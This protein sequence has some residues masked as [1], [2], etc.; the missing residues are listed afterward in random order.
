MPNKGPYQMYPGENSKPSQYES[1]NFRD[2]DI[3]KAAMFPN[4]YPQNFAHAAREASKAGDKSFQY[5]GETFPVTSKAGAEMHHAG[6]YNAQFH[7]G[8][9]PKRETK[10]VVKDTT[11]SK[12]EIIIQNRKE[13]ANMLNAKNPPKPKPKNP[14]KYY[15]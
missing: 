14:N 12:A 3:K 6:M 1:V 13:T 8:K 2:A 9:H 4:M 7:G 10:T 5:G 15:K 11:P